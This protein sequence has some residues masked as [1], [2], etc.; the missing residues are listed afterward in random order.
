MCIELTVDFEIRFAQFPKLSKR[1]SSLSC[2]ASEHIAT[3]E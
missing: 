1:E 3:V 2:F